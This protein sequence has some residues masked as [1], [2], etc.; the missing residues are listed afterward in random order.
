MTDEQ[1]AVVEIV[2]ASLGNTELYKFL[3]SIAKAKNRGNIADELVNFSCDVVY[4]I[5]NK[6]V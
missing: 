6:V 4:R 1:K 3:D 2:A 5:K